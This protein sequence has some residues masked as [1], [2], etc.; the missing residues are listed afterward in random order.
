MEPSVDCAMWFLLACLM[1]FYN[2]KEHTELGN[3]QN[4]QFEKG[5]IR[6][7]YVTKSC[8]YGH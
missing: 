5:R 1:P 8:V 3:I 2:E 6:E 7:F 4:V